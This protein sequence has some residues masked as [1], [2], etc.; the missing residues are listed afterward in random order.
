MST[1]LQ[2]VGVPSVRPLSDRSAEF[3]C[4][5]CLIE[6][7]DYPPLIVVFHRGAVEKYC[8]DACAEEAGYTEAVVARIAFENAGDGICI[9]YEF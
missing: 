8:T 9:E 1:Q 4:S 7:G 6:Y 2:A 5:G 3:L